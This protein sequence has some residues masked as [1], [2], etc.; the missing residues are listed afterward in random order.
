MIRTPEALIPYIVAL[1]AFLAGLAWHLADSIPHLGQ[2]IVSGKIE[3]GG[4]F[5]LIDQDG[6]PR[7]DRDFRGRWM[8]IY[9]GYTH[10]PDVCPLTLSLM[11]D[12]MQRL[13]GK[14]SHIV[15]IFITVDP[16]RD[17][18]K[19]MKAYVASFGKNFLG[20]TGDAKSIALAE[21]EY[22]VAAIRH[23]LPGGDYAM[24]HSSTIYLMD[25][26]GKFVM[27]YDDS[28]KPDD[29]AADIAKRL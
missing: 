19:I 23:P 18:P 13:G 9:F 11:S 3:V 14:S 12:V 7:E 25:P 20:L 8:T 27:D 21:R 24:D 26:G 16:A 1:A 10:C 15:P 17:T 5:H 28:T 29:I 22:R 4:P 2:T 6:A